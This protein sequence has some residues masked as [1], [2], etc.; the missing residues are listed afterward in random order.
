MEGALR[1]ICETHRLRAIS[2]SLQADHEGLTLYLHPTLDQGIDPCFSG[3]GPSFDEALEDG[4][5]RIND[6]I[7]LVDEAQ[8]KAAG[9]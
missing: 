6:A 8:S 1:I 3:H 4:L 2:V 7:A 5:A 9:K